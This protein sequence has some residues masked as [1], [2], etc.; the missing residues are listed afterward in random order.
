MLQA[1]EIK[2]KESKACLLYKVKF[3]PFSSYIVDKEMLSVMSFKTYANCIWEA[4][5]D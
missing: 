4:H 5:L 1:W 2:L 3:G